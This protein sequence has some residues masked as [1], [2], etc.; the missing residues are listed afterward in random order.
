MNIIN[1][2]A[3]AESA[4]EKF[5]EKNMPV[6]MRVCAGFYAESIEDGM[7][8][9]AARIASLVRGLFQLTANEAERVAI[10]LNGRLIMEDYAFILRESLT[11]AAFSLDWGKQQAAEA[12]Q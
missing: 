11:G 12:G 7:S 6:L 5:L 2:Q 1:L 9:E 8:P 4:R 3:H 10:G